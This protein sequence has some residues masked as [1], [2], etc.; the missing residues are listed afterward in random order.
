VLEESKS[1]ELLLPTEVIPFSITD[2]RAKGLVEEWLEAQQIEDAALILPLIGIYLPIWLLHVEGFVN[3]TKMGSTRSDLPHARMG[4]IDVYE[5]RTMI[6]GSKRFAPL[7]KEMSEQVNWDDAVEY[8]PRFLVDWGAEIYE[9]S[10]TEAGHEARNEAIEKT[11]NSLRSLSG[12]GPH[13]DMDTSGVDI[14]SYRLVLVPIWFA[15]YHY[16]GKDHPILINGQNG[17]LI[18]EGHAESLRDLFFDLFE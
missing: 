8:D 7:L 6:L 15:R 13:F 14:V 18:S 17:T 11:R 1:L 5:P 3:W 4:M 2:L 9:V 12:M 10:L 16:K